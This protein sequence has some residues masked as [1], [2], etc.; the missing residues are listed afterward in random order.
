M[1]RIVPEFIIEYYRAGC[2][3]QDFQP[4]GMFIF[5]NNP[6]NFK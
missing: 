5:T 4:A 1:H 2:R 6:T 3:R